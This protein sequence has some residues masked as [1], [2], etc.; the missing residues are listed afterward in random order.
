VISS[1]AMVIP[2]VYVHH[3]P[4]FAEDVRRCNAS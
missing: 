4:S 3:V 1:K 2:Y